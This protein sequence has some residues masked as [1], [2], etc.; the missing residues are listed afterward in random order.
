MRETVL[1]LLTL[2]TIRARAGARAT[3]TMKG[4]RV[5]FRTGLV[6]P[7]PYAI[8]G[9]RGMFAALAVEVAYVSMTTSV[10]SASSAGG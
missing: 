1:L 10:R 4:H 2:K 7:L 9:D 3:M 5:P 6:S 8:T